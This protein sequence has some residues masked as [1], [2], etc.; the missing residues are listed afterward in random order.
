MPASIKER[1]RQLRVDKLA[2]LDIG[3]LPVGTGEGAGDIRT[4]LFEIQN[5]QFPTTILQFSRHLPSSRDIL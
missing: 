5:G 1:K 2:I 3:C 4:T